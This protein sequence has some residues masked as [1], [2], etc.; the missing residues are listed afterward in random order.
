MPYAV[1]KDGED[2]VVVNTDTGEEKARH[3]PPDAE[4]KAEKQVKLLHGLE[5]GMVKNDG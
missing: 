2:Y 1:H 4:E 3:S 5:H